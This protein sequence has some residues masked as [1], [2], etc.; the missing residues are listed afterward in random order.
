VLAGARTRLVATAVNDQ[1]Q[2]LKGRSLTWFAGRQRLGAS[3]T[4]RTR[5]PGGRVTL[6]LVVRSANGISRTVTE[7]LTVTA[8]RLRVVSL[9]VPQRVKKGA[10]TVAIMLRTST[11]AK[12][13]VGR[14]HYTVRTRSTRITLNLPT[15]PA[16]GL[17]KVPFTLSPTSR[18]VTGRIHGSVWVVRP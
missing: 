11:T 14:K 10:K 3:P 13:A 7:R 16:V 18:S 15:R 2:A 6:R 5:L 4:L 1:G 8:T 9:S 12:L 17:V